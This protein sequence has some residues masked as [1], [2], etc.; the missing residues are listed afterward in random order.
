MHTIY[1]EMQ[2]LSSISDGARKRDMS[3]EPGICGMMVIRF[4][5][6]T[7]VMDAMIGRP[8]QHHRPQNFCFFLLLLFVREREN[9][10]LYI[11]IKFDARGWP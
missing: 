6:H 7:K 5:D 1:S 10:A 11:S 9:H 2:K 4:L 3:E 8:I